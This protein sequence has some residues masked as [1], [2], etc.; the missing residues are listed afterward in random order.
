MLRTIGIVAGFGAGLAAWLTLGDRRSVAALTVVEWESTLGF[1]VH[2]LLVGVALLFLFIA[3]RKVRSDRGHQVR[4]QRAQ[5]GPRTR[6]PGTR[7]TVSDGHWL[8][9]VR[10]AAA[11]IQFEAGASLTIDLNRVF[12]VVLELRRMPVEKTRRSIAHL[13]EWLSVVP[14]PPRVKLVFIDCAE[15]SVPRHHQVA[16]VIAGRVERN[17]FHVVSQEESVEI[18]FH[19]PGEVWPTV[20][21]V[22]NFQG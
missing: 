15:A 18:I 17:S 14:H 19:N 11:G 1:P 20:Q 4:T 13:S 6:V 10:S 12:P 8:S 16:G 5:Q 3:P 22:P 21:V 9:E 7:P 2:Y